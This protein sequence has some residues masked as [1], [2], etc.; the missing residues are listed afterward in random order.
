[1]EK[2]IDMLI[3]CNQYGTNLLEYATVSE[4]L[5]DNR[6]VE[7][8]REKDG[9]FKVREMC[10]EWASARLTAD[11]LRAWG[12]ELIDMANN[13]KLTVDDVLTLLGDRAQW[14][15]EEGAADMRYITECVR[16]LRAAIANGKTRTEILADY[17]LNDE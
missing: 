14:C 12:Q 2:G 9:C 10:D 16:S 3:D 13:D 15:R 17:S 11:Q 1:L 6:V 8:V 7:V 5:A 4:A